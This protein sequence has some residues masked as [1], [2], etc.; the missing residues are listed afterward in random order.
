LKCVAYTKRYSYI[1]FS[2]TSTKS[3]PLVH[4]RYPLLECWT[5]ILERITCPGSYVTPLVQ[6]VTT[7]P[8]GDI[9]VL[10]FISRWCYF[11]LS[12]IDRLT[13]RGSSAW[14]G[15]SPWPC[16]LILSMLD[17]WLMLFET[18][19]KTTAIAKM[20]IQCNGEAEVVILDSPGYISHI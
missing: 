10:L 19:M 20:H 8:S 7:V 1:C 14:N 9:L 4:S 16:L 18:K 5:N 2:S 13:H 17:I 12:V 15:N 6:Q 11:F 3:T